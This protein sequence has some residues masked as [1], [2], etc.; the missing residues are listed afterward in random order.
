MDEKFNL[1]Y[2]EEISYFIDCCRQD[3]EADV[4]MRGVDGLEALK[5]VKYI[6]ESAKQGRTIKNPNME[7]K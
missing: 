2:V 1:G 4:G 3:K 5:V 7:V 6:Y